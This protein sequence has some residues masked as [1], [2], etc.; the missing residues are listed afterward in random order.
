M[1]KQGRQ[2][3]QPKPCINDPAGIFT[4]TAMEI[5]LQ[6]QPK[7]SLPKNHGVKGYTLGNASTV[8]TYEASAKPLLE[9]VWSLIPFSILFFP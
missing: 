1:S 2:S 6:L 4:H 8:I 5:N 7:A 3:W 9:Y